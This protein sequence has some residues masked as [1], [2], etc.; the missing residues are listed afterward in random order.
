MASV[1]DAASAFE[2]GA[3]TGDRGAWFRRTEYLSTSMRHE[4]AVADN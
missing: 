1:A 3:R 2:R 4:G